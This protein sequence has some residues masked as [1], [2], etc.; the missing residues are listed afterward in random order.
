MLQL[1]PQICVI[2][3]IKLKGKSNAAEQD[4][5]LTEEISKTLREAV[6]QS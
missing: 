3:Q 5:K 1:H 2:K 6:Q 4:K